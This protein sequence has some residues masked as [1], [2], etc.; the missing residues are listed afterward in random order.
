MAS[1]AEHYREAERRLEDALDAEGGS[2]NE[3]YLLGA[4][5]VHALLA[6]APGEVAAAPGEVPGA[7]G[8]SPR[9]VTFDIT[10]PNAR[11]VIAQALEEYA[12][13]QQDMAVTGDSQEMRLEWAVIADEFRAQAETAE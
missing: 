12:T 3:R 10:D 8:P 13:R 11:H 6:N 1:R 4:A 7:G 2:D 9:T 5:S